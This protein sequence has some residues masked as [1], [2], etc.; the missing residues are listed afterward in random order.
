MKR[1]GM[2]IAT[3]CAATAVLVGCG[4]ESSVEE[5]GDAVA[6]VVEE[7]SFA[8]SEATSELVEGADAL[9]E[10]FRYTVYEN[11]VWSVEYDGTKIEA[12]PTEEG[13]VFSFTDESFETAGTNIVEI[14]TI[15]G[16]TAEDVIAAKKSEFGQEDVEV[17]T[18]GFG[19]TGVDAITYIVANTVA[20]NPDETSGLTT[21]DVF[22][23]VPSGDDVILMESFRTIGP[24][25]SVEYV[26][27]GSF[28]HLINTFTLK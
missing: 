2:L 14:T 10:E 22:T 1:F 11:D 24:D 6:E 28:E 26:V 3:M 21:S 12:F 7:A 15:K 18:S 13:V 19:S 27:D 16:K 25:D 5:T 17:Y 4:S 8:A 23:A 20:E 9:D